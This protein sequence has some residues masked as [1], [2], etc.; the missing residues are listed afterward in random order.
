MNIDTLFLQAQGR[1]ISVI[2][3]SN[4]KEAEGVLEE[5]DNF[6]MDCP[7]LNDDPADPCAN[8]PVLKLCTT[9]RELI[10]TDG[11]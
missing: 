5:L 4:K 6:C 7:V 10:E 8:C 3:P 9:I 11:K 1:T 2:K